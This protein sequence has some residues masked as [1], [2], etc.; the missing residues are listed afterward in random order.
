MGN[1]QNSNFYFQISKYN[2]EN[3]IRRFEIE[4]TNLDE[5]NH[6]KKFSWIYPIICLDAQVTNEKIEGIFKDN[7]NPTILKFIRR[8]YFQITNE[9]VK[10]FDLKKIKILIFLLTTNASDLNYSDKVT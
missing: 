5:S 8:D 1:K 7:F 6:L 2:E 4:E 3:S 10:S 9:E